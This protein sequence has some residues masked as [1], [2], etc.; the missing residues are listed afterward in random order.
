VGS[1]YARYVALVGLSVLV[2]ITLYTEL[3][4]HGDAV[5][6]RPGERMP[7]FAAPLA[8]GGPRGDV[9]VATR[10]HEGQAGRRP[11]C[12]V[13][14]AG[15]LNLCQL[16]ER[17]PVVLAL[18]IDGGS[19]TKVLGS[20]QRLAPTFPGV[21]FAAVA[22]KAQRGAVAKLVRSER[23]TVPVG[24]DRDGILAGLYRMA[25]CPQLTFAYPGGVVQGES[26]LDTP[27]QP[28]LASRVAQLTAA[29][30]ARG[31]RPPA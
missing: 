25:G 18:F 9:N 19:C 11:A 26:I 4:H 16:Y 10:P 3:T 13:R 22:I 23:L 8:I 24:V 28:A 29:A 6:L 27:S 7:P 5:G 20:M 2:G 15:I 17:G 14:G 31:W 30:R 21:A 12:R 1:R